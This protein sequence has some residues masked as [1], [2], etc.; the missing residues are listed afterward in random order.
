MNKDTDKLLAIFE[1]TF[2]EECLGELKYM[3]IGD[4]NTIKKMLQLL[5]DA[6]T[7]SFV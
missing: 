7:R 2:E 6:D 5:G 4:K 3:T 1:E